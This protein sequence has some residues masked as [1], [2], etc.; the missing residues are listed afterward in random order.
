MGFTSVS[1]SFVRGP[2]LAFSII[3]RSSANLVKFYG[4]RP[5]Y[6]ISLTFSIIWLV[7]CAVAKNIQTMI[8]GR[9]MGGLSGAAFL[10]VAGA[11]VGDLFDHN[12]LQ[13][14]MI[15]YSGIQFMG[16]ELG[17]IIGGFVNYY[18]SW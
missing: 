5:I 14:P 17:P 9:L 10:S 11:S 6:I 12:G 8:V 1:L 13:F 2:S 7:L 15:M 3:M 18:T 16:P 4:R